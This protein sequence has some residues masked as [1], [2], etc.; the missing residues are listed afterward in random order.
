MVQLIK[1]EQ[2]ISA[3][4]YHNSLQSLDFYLVSISSKNKR[5][6]TVQ[7]SQIR[8]DLYVN[9]LLRSL[10]AQNIINHKKSRKNYE[11]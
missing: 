3:I 5:I 8:R 4:N 10:F 6:S 2:N 7:Y 11:W 1:F 9:T